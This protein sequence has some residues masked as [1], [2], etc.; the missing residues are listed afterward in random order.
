MEAQTLGEERWQAAPPWCQPGTA[1]LRAT[2]LSLRTSPSPLSPYIQ[3][4]CPFNPHAGSN[5]SDLP[6]CRL[7]CLH[8]HHPLPS[9]A[10]ASPAS[11]ST[12]SFVLPSCPKRSRGLVSKG[13]LSL[14]HHEDVCGDG[15]IRKQQCLPNKDADLHRR[16]QS[17]RQEALHPPAAQGC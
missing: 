12:P 3:S 15:P 4:F 13:N 6:A 2:N 1:S 11:S 14:P 5:I 7:T 10:S 17:N 16:D 8:A 9:P